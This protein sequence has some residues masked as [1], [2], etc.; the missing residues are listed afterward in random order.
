M[1][2]HT[3]IFIYVCMYIYVYIYIHT[4]GD[5]RIARCVAG[6]VCRGRVLPFDPSLSST[7]RRG[8]RRGQQRLLVIS[9]QCSMHMCAVLCSISSLCSRCAWRDAKKRETPAP[10][11]SAVSPLFSALSVLVAVVFVLS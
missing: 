3:H 10:A 6:Y 11:L 4:Y 1:Y 2:T 8:A 9:P 5:S 7:A